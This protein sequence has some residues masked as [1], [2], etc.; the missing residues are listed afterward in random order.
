MSGTLGAP[1]WLPIGIQAI[2]WEALQIYL[3][4]VRPSLIEARLR[5]GL[6]DH[7]FLLVCDG[8]SRESSVGDLYTEAAFRGSWGRALGRL[9]ARYGDPRLIVGKALGTT[10]HALRHSYGGLLADLGLK[11][12][13]IQEC[14]HHVSPFSQL[15]Y[16]PAVQ[17]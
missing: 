16:T 11:P 17:R 14:M 6:P 13:I 2:S 15:T 1:L 7:P 9:Q 4:R 3:T 5:R 12:D 8:S 10:P